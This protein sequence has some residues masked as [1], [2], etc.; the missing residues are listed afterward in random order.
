[1]ANTLPESLAHGIKVLWLRLCSKPLKEGPPP[2]HRG[3]ALTLQQ[4]PVPSQQLGKSTSTR[5]PGARG[6]RATLATSQQLES[7]I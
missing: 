7:F 4:P 5:C 3:C 1:M 6:Q 2:Q